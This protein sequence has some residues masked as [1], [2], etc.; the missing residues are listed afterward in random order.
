MPQTSTSARVR[1]LD[2]QR[3]QKKDERFMKCSRTINVPHRAHGRPSCPYAA[4]E[5]SK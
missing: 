3:G 1:A 4:N 2:W 5:R